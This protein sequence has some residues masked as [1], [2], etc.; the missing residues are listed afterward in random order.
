MTLFAERL[1]STVANLKKTALT[2]GN[3]SDKGGKPGGDGQE[4]KPD[5]NGFQ[6]EKNQKGDRDST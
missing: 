4:V 2:G 1:Y 3:P 6:E 5:D